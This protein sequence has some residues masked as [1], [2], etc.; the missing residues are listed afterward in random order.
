MLSDSSHS[1]STFLNTLPALGAD[2]ATLMVSGFSAGSFTTAQMMTVFPQTF[3][4][5]GMLNG[6]MT[7]T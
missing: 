5:A 1:S 7:N 2:P 6:G 4:C 3:S